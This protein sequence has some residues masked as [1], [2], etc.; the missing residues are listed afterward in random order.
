MKKYLLFLPVVAMI[1]LASIGCTGV[2]TA[3]D[4]GTLTLN[5]TDAPVDGDTIAGV[6]ISIT[7]VEIG[8]I[9][10]GEVEWETLADY[11]D[12]P[13]NINLLDYTNGLAYQI[14]QYELDAGQYNQIRFILDIKDTSQEPPT[15]PECYVEFTDEATEPLFVP[16]GDQSGYKAVGSFEVPENG[17]VEVTVDFDVRKAL[18]VT[19][20]GTNQRYILKP[21][22]RL[23]VDSSAGKITGTITN[24]SEQPQL[25]VF[26]YEDGDWDISEADEPSEGNARFP[27]A[28]T[29]GKVDDETGEFTLAYL[30]QDETYDLVV[31]AYDADGAFIEV[32][33][34]IDDIELDSNNEP[35]KTVSTDDLTPVTP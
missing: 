35:V 23:V 19:G 5:I 34:T 25:V 33:G 32:L 2:S 24:V 3:Q 20:Q 18:H 4:I 7:G 10:S 14:G 26:A 31:V 17:G 28:L 12:E 21:T 16:S 15:T 22:L 13:V 1:A 27:N 6:W 11:T 8:R 9:T 30:A 29:S